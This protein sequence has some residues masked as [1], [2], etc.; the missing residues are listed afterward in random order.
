MVWTEKVSKLIDPDRIAFTLVIDYLNKFGYQGFAQKLETEVKYSTLDLQGLDLQTVLKSILSKSDRCDP[1]N[2][3]I[4][5]VI[6]Y[7]NKHGYQGLAQELQNEVNFSRIDLQGLDLST[8]IKTV[9][10]VPRIIC[11]KTSTKMSKSRLSQVPETQMMSSKR[12]MSKSKVIQV[13]EEQQPMSS[14]ASRK[15]KLDNCDKTGT[16]VLKLSDPDQLDDL[17]QRVTI[18][19][20]FIDKLDDLKSLPQDSE[21]PKVVKFILDSNIKVRKSVRNTFDIIPKQCKRVYFEKNFA[22]IRSD[23]LSGLRYGDASE[24]SLILKQW[25]NLVKGVPIYV[26]EKFLIQIEETTLSWCQ[27]LLGA[28][29]SR[30]MTE[31]HRCASQLFNA[32]ISLKKRKGGL[33]PEEDELI[34]ALGARNAPSTEWKKLATDMG[35]SPISLSAR[36]H[37]LKNDKGK[38]TRFAR[39]TL[40]E[41]RKILE[42]VNERFDISSSESL[43]SMKSSDLHGLTKVIARGQTIIVNRWRG[44]LMPAI[45]SYLYGVPEIQ[46]RNEFLKF[47]IHQKVMNLTSINWTDVL[48]KWPYQT[49]FN[50]TRTLDIAS[51]YCKDNN[52]DANSP[53]YKQVSNYL[54]HPI[55][56]GISLSQQDQRRAVLKIFDEIR[57]GHKQ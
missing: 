36:L 14:N 20:L 53:L 15:R 1:E 8:V 37:Y 39:F 52:T 25:N 2:V 3:S 45:L 24:E 9:T 35:R 28:F 46:W 13:P 27:T 38:S 30:D 17:N 47:I 41:D 50:L 44:I 29:L 12:K 33:T 56:K 40:E 34:L 11:D 5:L 54:S 31:N 21:I 22:Y 43:K 49:K 23:K 10:K 48:Q 42:Y 16:K 19:D 6:D 18:T 51:R 32:L 7:F 26:P 57:S 4:N 55:K